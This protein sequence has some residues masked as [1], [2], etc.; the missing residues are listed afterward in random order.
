VN[1][2]IFE[3]LDIVYNISNLYLFYRLNV[4]LWGRRA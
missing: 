2:S 3:E 1:Y 4:K